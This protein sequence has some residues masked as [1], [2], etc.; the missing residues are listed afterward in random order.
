M[1]TSLDMFN[2]NMLNSTSVILNL[3]LWNVWMGSI[4]HSENCDIFYKWIIIPMVNG[5]P[6]DTPSSTVESVLRDHP[7]GHKNVV[8]QDKRSLVTGSVMLKCGSLC[9]KCVVCQDR[10][11]LKIGFTIQNISPPDYHF[12]TRLSF[13]CTKQCS[14]VIYM[15]EGLHLPLQNITPGSIFH[16]SPFTMLYW[17]PPYFRIVIRLIGDWTWYLD[18]GFYILQASATCNQTWEVTTVLLTTLSE[19]NYFTLGAGF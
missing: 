17:Y 7:I 10:W 13:H 9:Q 1:A 2:R 19:H 12:S 3:D 5:S 14:Y 8:C 11:S 4:Y 15:M 6:I 18:W 16:M